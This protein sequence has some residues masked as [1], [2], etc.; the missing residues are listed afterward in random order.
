MTKSYIQ[1]ATNIGIF[2]ES[3]QTLPSPFATS[4]MLSP[5]K[6]LWNSADCYALLQTTLCLL[7]RMHSLPHVAHQALGS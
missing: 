4:Q 2:N 1:Y 5:L 3:R 6:P 7:N